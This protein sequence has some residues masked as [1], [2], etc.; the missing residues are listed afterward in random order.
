AFALKARAHAHWASVSKYCSACGSPLVPGAHPDQAGGMVCPACLRVYFPRISPAV[1]VLVHRGREILLAHNKK[2]PPGRHGLI[3]G[4]VEAGESLEE[5]LRRELMEEAGIQIREPRYVVSQP[6]PF[7][8]SL[9]LGFEAEYLSGEARPDGEEL[10]S[11]GW[12]V[13]DKLPGIPPKGSV[14]RFLIDRF[15]EADALNHHS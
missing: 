9:M 12:F 7:P 13:P 15:C 3:A 6:W 11:L 8:D 1:I 10:D 4:F 2:F 14:A 5:T